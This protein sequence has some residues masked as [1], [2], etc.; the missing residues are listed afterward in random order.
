[1][2]II[3][4][5]SSVLVDMIGCELLEPWFGSGLQAVTT[6]LVLH[7]MN[8]KAQRSRLQRFVDDKKLVVEALGAEDM[9]GVVSLRAEL[10][11]KV[12]LE[13]ASALYLAVREKGVLLTGDNDLRKAAENRKIEVHGLLW[14]FDELVT[15]GRV[16]QSVAAERL[17]K[18]CSQ[19]TCRLPKQ[20]CNQRIKKW[21]NQ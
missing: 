4:H 18:L 11:S 2:K 8:R 9:T 21:R 1:M 3:V 17:E 10:S 12:S 6:R 5:D 20:D 16:L 13:D 14:I 7:E 15:R 19:G